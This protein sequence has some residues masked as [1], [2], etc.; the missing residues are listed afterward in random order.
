MMLKLIKFNS[1]IEVFPTQLFA[2]IYL[3]SDPSYVGVNFVFLA[4]VL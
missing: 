3:Y 2:L 1:G 4:I